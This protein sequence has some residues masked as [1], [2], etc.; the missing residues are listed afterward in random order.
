MSDALAERVAA[1]LAQHH[2][3][4][5]ATCDEDGPWA[6]AV[7]FAFEGLELY[8]LSSPQ[9]RHARA[10]ERD[11]RVAVTIQRDYRDW[12][13]IT[14]IQA[15]GR[16]APVEGDERARVRRVYGERFPI[17]SRRSRGCIG[18]ASPRDACS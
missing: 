12:P 4:T 18:T 5:L 15:E 13:E 8:F 1:F 17:S 3:M 16:A 14:G 11:P 2:V 10:I 9:S 6:A 7:F